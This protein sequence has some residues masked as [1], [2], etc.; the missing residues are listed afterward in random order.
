MRHRR[1][2]FRSSR[3]RAKANAHPTGHGRRGRPPSGC[4]HVE[5]RLQ[6]RLFARG[7]FPHCRP[8]CP[9]YKVLQDWPI[10]GAYPCMRGVRAGGGMAGQV[11]SCSRCTDERPHLANDA[12][13]VR[14]FAR[15]QREHGCPEKRSC[16]SSR[17]IAAL[18]ERN[19]EEAHHSASLGRR[20]SWSAATLA[21]TADVG[22]L[23]Q[24]VANSRQG[25]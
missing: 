17:E 16:Q 22:Y 13:V 20:A 25:K 19:D 23:K 10:L 8:S 21:G 24:L 6:L 7:W 5:T 1:A 14:D 9:R 4:D 3:R 18:L 11:C 2:T 12:Q 15:P